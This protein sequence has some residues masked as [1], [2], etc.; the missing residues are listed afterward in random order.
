MNEF[1]LTLQNILRRRGM[2]ISD[3]AQHVEY[4]PSLFESIVTGK[5]RQMPVDFFVR[6]GSL[7]DL[8][9]AE[10]EALIR[11]WA[12]GV[13]LWNWPHSRER[14]SGGPEAQRRTA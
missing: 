8:T 5:S 7:L 3:L 1:Q 2:S 10:K 13:D 12:F 14:R 11:A 9:E 4:A 6:L